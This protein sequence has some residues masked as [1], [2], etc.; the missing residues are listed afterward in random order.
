MIHVVRGIPD[1]GMQMQLLTPEGESPLRRHPSVILPRELHP[2]RS[3]M[4]KEGEFFL[5]DERDS[6]VA[7]GLLAQHNPGMEVRI[8]GLEQIAQC[9]AAKMVLKKISEYG[10]LPG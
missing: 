1:A 7:M 6:D 5:V 3:N 9:P 4:A 10:V 8:Y 2:E